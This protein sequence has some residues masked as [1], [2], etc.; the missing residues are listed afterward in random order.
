MG[1]LLAHATGIVLLAAGEL[2]SLAQSTASLEIVISGL[3][4][5]VD[6]AVVLTGPGGTR[7]RIVESVLVSQLGSGSYALRADRVSA[8]GEV[9]APSPASHNLT[10]VAGRRYRVEIRYS[11]VAGDT[12]AGTILELGQ[13]WKQ[14]GLELT[15][16]LLRTNP[17]SILLEVTLTSRRQGDLVLRLTQDNFSASSNLG[18]ALRIRP[19]G[20]SFVVPPG[21]STRLGYLTLIADLADPGLTEIIVVVSGISSIE[22]ARWR[23]PIE[24]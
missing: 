14:G 12:A 22:E 18:Q 21:R 5:G 10:L 1:R 6:A 2:W 13:S 3:P 23:I 15:L 19:V 9:Y 24:K 20:G 17:D 16:R 7:L 8:G 11:R 4:Q